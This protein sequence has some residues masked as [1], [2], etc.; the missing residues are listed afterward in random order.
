MTLENANPR[1]AFNFYPE[2][3][4]A[5]D[6]L[7]GSGIIP[8]NFEV[9]DPACGCGSIV[10]MAEKNGYHALGRDIRRGDDFLLSERSFA[11]LDRVVVSNPPYGTYKEGKRL[12]EAFVEHAFHLGASAVFVLLPVPWVA[13]RVFWLKKNG[14][15]GMYVLRPRLSILPYSAM[16]R[17][18]WPQGGGKDYAWYH[19]T[20]KRRRNGIDVKDLR[21]DLTLD[22]REAWTWWDE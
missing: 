14:W 6:A 11:H 2:F 15:C 19:F 13:S 12:E 18:E 1:E 5:S 16:A 17:G 10:R 8:P 9:Y 3:P 21:R 20:K 7:L 4:S 22:T